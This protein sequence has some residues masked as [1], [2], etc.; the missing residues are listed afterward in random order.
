MFH[1]FESVDI[2]AEP[3]PPGDSR[4][5]LIR[6]SQ[7]LFSGHDHLLILRKHLEELANSR[8][9]GVPGSLRI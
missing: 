4:E 8:V 5:Y 6:I 3:H 1:L 7:Q 9:Q 2:R